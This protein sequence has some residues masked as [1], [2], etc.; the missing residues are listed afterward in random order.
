MFYV[1]ST[2]K[3]DHTMTYAPNVSLEV[4]YLHDR[5]SP[6][7]PARLSTVRCIPQLSLSNRLSGMPPIS[8]SVAWLIRSICTISEECLSFT[9][10]I[11]LRVALQKCVRKASILG[12]SQ[13]CHHTSRSC[14]AIHISR[15]AYSNGNSEVAENASQ[16]AET[17]NLSKADAIKSPPAIANDPEANEILSSSENKPA[18]DMANGPESNS[19]PPVIKDETVS[20]AQKSKNLDFRMPQFSLYNAQMGSGRSE[21]KPAPDM[22]NDPEANSTPPVIE[23]DPDKKT[24]NPSNADSEALNKSQSSNNLEFRRYHIF[25]R[26]FSEN[27]TVDALQ[28]FYSRFGEVIRCSIRFSDQKNQREGIVV[29]SSKKAMYRAL[30]SLP[31]RIC[32]EKVRAQK[33]FLQ[34]EL[35]LRVQNLSPETT[36]ESL[37][38]FYSKFGNLTQCLV[39]NNPETGKPQI[40]YVSF[41]SHGELDRA[42]DAQPHLIDGS[43][44]FL[45]YGT[46][47]LDLMVKE[48]PNGITEE[49]LRTFFSQYGQVR[50]CEWMTGKT[51][52]YNHAFVGFSTLDEVNRAMAD[53][54]H[55]IDRK[56]L[57][58]EYAGKCSSYIIFVGSLPQ[59]TTT[60][61]LFKAFNKFGK[62]VYL[63][64]LVR[65]FDDS[66]MSPESDRIG[67]VH[68]GTQQEADNVLNSGPHMVEGAIVKVDLSTEQ[69]RDNKINLLL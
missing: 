58:T 29:F 67:F 35:S 69:Y 30:S 5:V 22:T 60:S 14:N 46:D 51:G 61:A 33:G 3:S 53:R 27:V 21:N 16:H 63:E 10:M 66:P 25:V 1:A 18:L 68:Y 24:Q 17:N 43:E 19:T 62:I 2:L 45:G 47:E 4:V 31:H 11:T 15:L 23:N 28:E 55:V 49:S 42:L 6:V 44:V 48:V 56:L 54:P 52:I 13:I 65:K 37:R 36:E 50:R 64:V 26:G 7:I 8:V 57:K 32:G 41:A 40:G 39:K 34:K 20:K 9:L 12:N 38:D 59:S